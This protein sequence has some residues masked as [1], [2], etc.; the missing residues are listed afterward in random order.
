MQSQQEQE[1]F[2]DALECESESQL[3][4]FLSRRCGDDTALRSRVEKLLE[5]HHSSDR[6]LDLP[7]Q[8][9]SSIAI[10]DDQVGDVIG[11]YKLL[12]KIGQG[13]MGDVY[14]AEQVQPMRR[15]VALKI[16]KPGLDT[17]N[18]IA[19]FE[20]ERQAL[21]LMD[22]PSITRVLDAGTTEFGRPFFVMDLVRGTHVTDYCRQR[23]MPVRERLK[24]FAQICDAVQHAHQK[25][26]I[27]RDLKP[28]NILVTNHDGKPLPR[29]I[30]FGIAKAIDQRLTEKTLFT[31]YRTIVGTPGYMSPEQADMTDQDIDTRSD[32]YSL[33]VLLYVLLTDTTPF[34]FS[35]KG[36]LEMIETVKNVEPELASTRVSRMT[37]NENHSA[38]TSQN[39]VLANLIRGD[40]DWITMRCLSKSRE[41]RY[42]TASDLARDVR[43]FLD[44]DPVDAAAPTWAYRIRK[45]YT[46]HRA[47]VIMAFG[48]SI[49]VIT[50]GIAS[51]IFGVHSH[52]AAQRAEQAEQLAQQRLI[53]ANQERNRAQEAEQELAQ[54]H[55]EQRNRAT[56]FKALA[57]LNPDIVVKTDPVQMPKLPIV[58]AIKSYPATMVRKSFRISEESGA[59]AASL[60]NE[61]VVFSAPIQPGIPLQ[62]SQTTAARTTITPKIQTRFLR[63]LLKEQRKEFGDT[64]RFVVSTLIALGNAYTRDMEYENA[65]AAYRECRLIQESIDDDSTSRARVNFLLALTH[66]KNNSPDDARR[67]LERAKSFLQLENGAIQ[68]TELSQQVQQALNELS[69][70]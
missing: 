20:S 25:G 6:I 62:K 33:G 7:A 54:M 42:E 56:F 60:G 40:L 14:M 4:E 59:P 37:T 35:G 58:P 52:F 21:A 55:R 31:Y 34:E 46:K 1:I 66:L 61:T 19:R 63:T 50:G 3:I 65:I 47:P 8:S 30:D 68:N 41:H 36:Y 28:G 17:K 69:A 67:C 24:L 11:N 32:I 22:H 12:E 2:Y 26:I 51:T 70:N 5:Y 39:R 29:I 44:G 10:H 16:I 27:H 9:T 53:E 38:K 43:R 13:G 57:E 48:I 18:V 15:K 49:A 64:D 23:Q 45:Y